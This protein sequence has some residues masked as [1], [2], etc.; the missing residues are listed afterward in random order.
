MDDLSSM[1]SSVLSDPEAVERIRSL[2]GSL[3]NTENTVDSAQGTNPPPT[4][5]YNSNTYQ[6]A[7][8]AAE[9]GNLNLNPQML[10][11][12]SRFAP[13]FGAMS[14]EDDNTRLMNSLKP[15][16]EE[17]KRNKIDEVSRLMQMMKVIPMLRDQKIL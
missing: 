10:E 9:L 11:M 13:L 2:A 12:I 17:S 16:L 15:F 4:Q 1:L 5:Q 8:P 7:P 6:Q 14:Q 3:M